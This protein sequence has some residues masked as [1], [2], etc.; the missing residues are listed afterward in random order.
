MDDHLDRFIIYLRAEKNASEYT[1]RNYRQEIDQFL[2]FLRREGVGSWEGVDRLVLRRYLAWLGAEGYAKSSIARKLSEL[3][4]FGQFLVRERIVEMNPFRAVS[5]PKVP[6]RLPNFLSVDETVALLSTPNASDPQGQRDRAILELLYASGMRVS[7]V[8]GLNLSQIDL[9]RREIRVW[10]KG[11]KERLVLLGRPA[12]GALR[13]YLNDGRR[14]LLGA[15]ANKPT[16]NAVLLNR[17]GDRLSVRSVQL[18]LDKYTRGA[19]ID[20]RVTPHVLRHTF[21]THLL[22]GGADLRAVQELLG[23][24]QLS[25]TQIYT[26]ITQT[27]ARQVYLRAHPRAKEGTEE[28]HYEN[29]L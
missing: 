22:D 16:T 21:A 24:A 6:R 4:S 23:H 20:R 17:F 11:G 26:H 15:R 25:T 19:G 13:Q 9:E 2:G 8:V 29:H 10:G 3:R 5:S 12:V 1:I 14:Q 27:Q 7:E 18:I 28:G